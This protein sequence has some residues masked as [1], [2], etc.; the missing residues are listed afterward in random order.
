ML[1]GC[2]RE[3]K[4]SGVY[5]LHGTA[6]TRGGSDIIL[7]MRRVEALWTKI[8]GVLL[9]ILG[10]IQWLSPLIIYTGRE[11]IPHTP[12]TVKREKTILVP[13]PVAILIIAA[14]IAAFIIATRRNEP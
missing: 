4:S 8:V 3:A 2:A 11:R 1:L 9:V 6:K 14:G 5:L 12:Y 7:G 10:V 13:A